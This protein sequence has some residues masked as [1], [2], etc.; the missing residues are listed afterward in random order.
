MFYVSLDGLPS[1]YKQMA[2][3]ATQILKSTEREVRIAGVY[4]YLDNNI[5]PKLVSNGS[6]GV[7][8]FREE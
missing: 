2:Q 7:T 8:W 4:K 3:E 5:L 1:A 6:D